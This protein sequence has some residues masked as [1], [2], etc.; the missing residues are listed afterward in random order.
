MVSLNCFHTNE[1]FLFFDQEFYIDN[2]PANAVLIRT[3]DFIY[4]DCPGLEALYSKD[5]VLKYFDLYEYRDTWRNFANSF[6]ISLRSEKELI[7]YH[8]QHKRNDKTVWANRFRMDYT[9]E[10]YDRLF[11]NIF[12]DADSK[13]LYL[14]GSGC[15]AEQFIAQFGQYYKIEGIVD[16]NKEKWGKQVAGIEIYP[17][18]LLESLDVSF[19]VFVCIK[20]YENV[21]LQ[22]KDMGVRSYSVYNPQIDYERPVRLER[23]QEDEEP[24]RYHIGYVA[25]VFDLFHIGHL[26]LLRRAKEQCDYLIAGVVT[27]EQVIAAK[28][29]RPYI[30][31]EERLAIVQ[32]C[33]YVDEAVEIPADQPGT[34]DAFYRYHFD[35][36]FSGSDYADNPFWIAKKTFLQ[37]HGSDLVFFPYTQGI[38]STEIKEQ[39]SDNESERDK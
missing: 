32:A 31:F 30:S 34:E 10:E 13:I 19:K 18:S 24:K 26:N 16:N 12:K 20:L 2:F 1:G 9:Q 14:F 22:L 4:R 11:T 5:D 3:I 8:R 37:Q 23:R 25:G 28:K 38:S 29:T 15:Y 7:V 39:L 33:R 6:L 27:D 21:L 35:A 36:Q 17:P